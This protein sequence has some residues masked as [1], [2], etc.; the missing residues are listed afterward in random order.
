MN[1]LTVRPYAGED[2]LPA[3]TALL[4]H[5][6][7]VDRLDD[8]YAIDDLRLEFADPRIDTAKDLRLWEDADG[9]LLAFGQVWMDSS[10]DEVEGGLYWRVAPSAR[11][12][13]I[14]DD[15]LAWVTDRV[16]RQA[17]AEAKKARLNCGTRTEYAYGH[18]LPQHAGMAV[19]RHYFQ[20]RRPLDT[21][22][23]PAVL[24]AGFTLRHVASDADVA[25]WV[26]A[27][28]LSFIDHYNFHPVTLE[29]HRHWMQHPS[30]RPEHDLVA[31]AEDGT[32]AAF[33]L[34]QIDPA[35]NERNRR[36]DGW[37]GILGTRRGYRKLGL[38]RAVLLAGLHHLKA[39]GVENAR[40]N[41]DAENP[42]GALRLY[43]SVGFSVL[44]SWQTYEKHLN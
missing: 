28:N 14:E 36:N 20:M 16:L 27:F 1:T 31:V 2:D 34:C 19:V 5:C 17:Q 23:E 41:V 4:N 39:S 37:I 12:S 40:L 25:G 3:I 32:I 42:T 35:E 44:H 30:Y 33:D 26:D 10:D 13:G 6:D 9:A 21:P 43:E 8:N 15:I 18:T 24:P 38:G 22:I 7:A 29:T 11:G